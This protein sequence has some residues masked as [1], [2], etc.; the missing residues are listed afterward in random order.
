MFKL[1]SVIYSN[2]LKEVSSQQGC[3]YLYREKYMPDSRRGSQCQNVLLC[4]Y[5]MSDRM[6]KKNVKYF[7]IVVLELI[8]LFKKITFGLFNMCNGGTNCKIGLHGGG[9]MQNSLAQCFI[10]FVFSFGQEISFRCH[11]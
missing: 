8:F 9:E 5:I 2:V 4:W 1:G 6:I 7:Y 3:I 11:P 10:L